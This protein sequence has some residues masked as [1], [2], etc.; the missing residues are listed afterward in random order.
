MLRL[1]FNAENAPSNRILLDGPLRP[2]LSLCADFTASPKYVQHLPRIITRLH[3]NRGKAK[4]ALSSRS[5]HTQTPWHRLSTVQTSTPPLPLLTTASKSF[6]D[7]LCPSPPLLYH[8]LR[9]A[10]EAPETAVCDEDTRLRSPR[11]ESCDVVVV[12]PPSCCCTI[13]WGMFVARL[14]AS[15]GDV[16]P[17]TSLITPP[18]ACV[19]SKEHVRERVAATFE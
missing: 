15:M 4:V 11:L 12:V 9:S 1:C 2:L 6:S 18:T 10:V 3:M 8:E 14:Y 13:T 16:S 17:P 7:E 5:R 19:K